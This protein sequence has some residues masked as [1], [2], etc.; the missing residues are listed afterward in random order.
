MIEQAQA[1]AS[2][3]QFTELITLC[4]TLIAAPDAP[5]NQLLDVGVLL[6]NS[7]F[8]SAAENCFERAKAQDPADLR[9]EVNLANLARDRGQHTKSRHMYAGLLLRL[10]NH[11]AI[12]RNLLIGLE[13]DPQVSA[14]ERLAKAKDWGKWAI[15]GNER[16]RPPSPDLKNRQLRVGYISADFCQHTVGILV[17]KVLAAHQQTQPFAYSAGPIHD[18]ITDVI[19][20]TCQFRNIAKLSDLELARLIQEDQIDVL[21]DLSGHTAGSRLKVFA[22]R[23]APVQISWLGYFASTGLPYIDAVYLDSDHAPLGTDALFTEKIIHLAKGRFCYSPMP[24][25]PANV[26]PPP[27]FENGYISFGSFNN[28]AKYNAEVFDCW[29]KILLAVPHSRLILKWRNYNDEALQAATRQAF[30]D[31]GVNPDR[32]HLRGPSFHNDL[33]K[34]YADIDIALDPFP[35]SGGLT[36]CEALWMGVPLITL[37]QDRVVS[38]QGLAIANT[39]G[40]PEWVALNS[41]Q[42]I[43]IAITLANNPEQLGQLRQSLRQQMRPLTDVAGFTQALEQQLILSYQQASNMDKTVLHVGAGYRQS[44]ATL[45]PALQSWQELRL[46][47]DP[48]TKPDI[49]G[50]MLDMSGV[51]TASVDA[52]YSAHNIE[53]V[54]AHEVPL[55]LAEFLRVLKNDGFLLITCPDLQSVCALVANDQLGEAAYQSPAGPISP[56]DILYGYRPALAAGQIYMAHK[57][58]F[59]EKTLVAALQANG[60]SSIASKRRKA[61]LDLWAIACKTPIDKST[62]REL[63]NKTLP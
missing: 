12:R 54:Y 45:P 52:I 25:A 15:A 40:H 36:S 29:A 43:Q 32:I 38:R 47:I 60:F 51:P 31:L 57:T 27:C 18:E 6:Y 20:Q 7:G 11:P 16:P 9:A 39:I 21:V 8:L 13:Y 49:I 37:A 59:T 10:P 5:I 30:A 3:G 22:L 61:G 23:P 48:A 63:A 4:R 44:G 41:D 46:D 42:Y 24:F 35:F 28:T 55:V 58:G 34:Q 17:H 19:R 26:A 2:S 56:L 50:S 62:L 14:A 53:H 1:L 33:L